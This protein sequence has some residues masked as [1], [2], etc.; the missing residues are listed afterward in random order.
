MNAVG[1]GLLIAFTSPGLDV[2]K[3]GEVISKWLTNPTPEQSE[4]NR[5]KYRMHKR[6]FKTGV[7][8]LAVGYV[9]QLFAAIL[10]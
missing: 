6:G 1:A 4:K 2:T 8:L 5:R 10:G 7:V 3:N 9:I